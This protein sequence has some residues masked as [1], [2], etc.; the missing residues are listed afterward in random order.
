MEKA[1]TAYNELCYTARCKQL[2]KMTSRSD[3]NKRFQS[4]KIIL[5]FTEG[6]KTKPKNIKASNLT[7]LR[8]NQTVLK[9]TQSPLTFMDEFQC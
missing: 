1:V 8:Q 5:K 7:P 4:Q 3:I 2:P 6:S 9:W